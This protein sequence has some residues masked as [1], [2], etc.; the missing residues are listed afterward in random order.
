MRW[1]WGITVAVGVSGGCAVKKTWPKEAAKTQS[2]FTYAPPLVVR[3]TEGLIYAGQ[4]LFPEAEKAFQEVIQKVPT[5]SAAYYYYAKAA[6]AQGKYDTMR[7]YA[8]KAWA[9][10]SSYLPTWNLYATALEM[11]DELPK[12]A[13]L[14]ER[15]LQYFP[16][17][18]EVYFHLAELYRKMQQ[19]ERAIGIYDKMPRKGLTREDLWRLKLFTAIEANRS[20][21]AL[22]WVDS[23]RRFSPT[24]PEYYEIIINLYQW[25]GKPDS[26][27]V[28]VD[29]L[30]AMDVTNRFGWEQR[31]ER[32]RQQGTL[33]RWVKEVSS[34]FYPWEVK[35]WILEEAL[36][37]GLDILPQLDSL[38][39][40]LGY[41]SLYLMRADYAAQRRQWLKAFSDYREGIS[42]DPDSP[43]SWAGL[44]RS[45]Y[46]IGAWDS[47]FFYSQKAQNYYPNLPERYLYE[48]LAAW[49]QA[50]YVQAQ[51]ALSRYQALKPTPPKEEGAWALW[52][53]LRVALS[54]NNPEAAKEAYEWFFPVDSTLAKALFSTYRALQGNPFTSLPDV[55]E[56]FHSLI[57]AHVAVTQKNWLQ[58]RA[59]AEKLLQAAPHEGYRLLIQIAQE[60]QQPYLPYLEKLKALEPLNP[61][62]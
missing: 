56:P 49:R 33:A 38:L 4:S 24:K 55:E 28:Y 62:L 31:L 53:I 9:H 1:I 42:R 45:A 48:G 58:A 3:F 18:V 41:S 47:V 36:K 23:L 61:Q 52:A 30:L 21:Q 6:Y 60:T 35:E 39:E 25:L 11:T 50:H 22:V 59:C 12:A 8:H 10:D 43:H 29:K 13:R 7:A 2:E 17:E 34:P 19:Y 37:A 27:E 46:Y 40:R 51:R 14:L 26:V 16:T 44:L 54:R 57:C 20:L 5:S 32:A 15:A